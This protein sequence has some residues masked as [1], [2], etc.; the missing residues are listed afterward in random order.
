M[1]VLGEEEKAKETDII[2]EEIRN[3]MKNINLPI[4]KFNK[5]HVE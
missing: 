1:G 2:F 4:Q 5:I 3:W